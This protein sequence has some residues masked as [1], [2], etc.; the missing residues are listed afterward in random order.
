MSNEN[1][2]SSA[3]RPMG[4]LDTLH[5]SPQPV[6]GL[7]VREPWAGLI[8]A[9]EKTW[10]IRG[11]RTSMR[12]SIYIIPSGS[13]RVAGYCEIVDCIGPLTIEQLIENSSAHLTPP[14]ELRLLGLPYK[15]T[16]AWVLANPNR[17]EGPIPYRHPSGAITWVDL[18]ELKKELLCQ[19]DLEWRSME[20]SAH[21]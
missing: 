6:R 21:S 5:V 1:G 11:T 13:G 15:K 12:G 14:D 3:L 17:F 4:T 2:F 20:P 18:G 16:F 19:R 10:E 9:G 7:M 8:L